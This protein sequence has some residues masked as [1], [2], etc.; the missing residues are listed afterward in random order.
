MKRFSDE[1]V[2]GVATAAYQIEGGHD[3]DGKGESIWDRFSHTPGKVARGETGD[4]ANDHFH[5]WQEDLDLMQELGIEAYRFSIAWTRLFP[6][7]DDVREDRGFDFYDRLI[8]GLLERGIKPVPT[9]YHW[10]LP[11]ELQDQGGWENR[12]TA[13]RFAEYAAA[14]AEHFGSR[15]D[16]L[17]TINEPWVFAWLGHAMGYHAP[18]LTSQTAAIRA[19]HHATLAHNLAYDV[20]KD[21]A[22]KLSVGL[23]LSQ[24][25]PAVDDV[26]DPRQLEAAAVFDMNQNTFWM[27]AL[28]RGR[29][30][31][32]ATKHYGSDLADVVHDGDLATGKLDWLGINYYFNTRIGPVQPEPTD[33]R[34]RVIDEML[35]Y[36][37]E[38]SPIGPLTDMSWPITPQGFSGLVHRWKR[39]YGPDLPPIYITENGA[40]YD[41]EPNEEGK[42]T[43]QRRIEYLDLH[44]TELKEAI[45]LG[46]DVR[47]YFLWSFMDNFEWA[48]GY[49]K[50]FGI[51]H[52]DYK[53]QV[54]TAK[55][56]AYFYRD[57]IRSRGE[58]LTKRK[59]AV[60]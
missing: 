55:D 6:D 9:L 2:F 13:Y 46:A 36:A 47:G 19:S 30:P 25:M 34:V 16:L 31:Q 15:I 32:L 18:G 39:D 59:S 4:I 35:G 53:T 52:V 42:V 8:E 7:G 10:D 22:P 27:E 23:A 60:A 38:S 50:R 14:F 5:R 37:N 11:Q 17:A 1:F 21:I 41:D 49:A 12:E 3:K 58:H 48:V 54:R 33:T 40:A 51:V 43:D 28:I 45:E 24:S 26:S 57:V 44:L 56:S 29:Y 20:I